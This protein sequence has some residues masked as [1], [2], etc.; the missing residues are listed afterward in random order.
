[1]EGAVRIGYVASQ[2]RVY[3]SPVKFREAL[4]VRIFALLRISICC[5]LRNA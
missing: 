2:A 1:M 5:L 3:H 4:E